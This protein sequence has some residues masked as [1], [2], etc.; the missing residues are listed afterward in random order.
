MLNKNP[1]LKRLLIFLISPD[2]NPKPRLWVKW[3]VNPF[4]HKIGKR[5]IIRN[6]KSRID[7]FPWRRFEVG[8]FT[9]IEDFTAINNGVGDVIIGSNA[10]VGIGSVIIGPVTLGDKVGIGQ[11]VFISGFNHGYSNTSVDSN[12]Q[13]LVIKPVII[14]NNSH[15]GSNSVIL[16]GVHIGEGVQIGAGSVVT[17]NIPSYSVVVGNPARVIKVYNNLTKNWERV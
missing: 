9:L 1:K 10:R 15:V 4:F 3:F 11:N 12:E 13:N 17:K 6:Q 5:V 2:R 8:N 16:P 7:V 14:E